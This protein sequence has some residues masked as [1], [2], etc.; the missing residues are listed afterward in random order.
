MSES[1]SAIN[2]LLVC[3]GGITT[4]VLAKRLQ[5]QLLLQGYKD[6]IEATGIFN[7]E[8]KAKQ[9]DLI[10]VAPQAQVFYPQIR[11]IADNLA[12]PIEHVDEEALTQENISGVIEK[13]M[14]S[15]RGSCKIRRSEAT[16]KVK[17][18]PVIFMDII[19]SSL[20][21][22]VLI[23]VLAGIVW[24]LKTVMDWK[25]IEWLNLAL[26]KMIGFYLIFSIGYHYALKLNRQP[27]ACVVLCVVSCF[28][29]LP[30]NDAGNETVTLLFRN[31]LAWIPI[32]ALSLRMCPFLFAICCLAMILDQG[33][34]RLI[35]IDLD[36]RYIPF[37]LTDTLYISLVI[38]LFFILRMVL[39]LFL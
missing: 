33:M 1:I 20:K 19:K 10:L 7:L 3:V 5:Q 21:D 39:S 34:R 30:V 28:M 17:F 12:I 11:A 35:P 24:G 26:M 8:D 13:I 23:L 15:H 31:N 36:S 29:L 32:E 4:N 2:V 9:C 14:K 38:C 6:H 22:M 27:M 37:S 25:P 16:P 18:T